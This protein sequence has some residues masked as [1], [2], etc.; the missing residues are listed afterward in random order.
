LGVLVATM[1]TDHLVGGTN[2]AG[3]DQT[4]DPSF[5]DPDLAAAMDRNARR[6]LRLLR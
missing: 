3:W 1:G 6:L 2:F 5:G 4:V